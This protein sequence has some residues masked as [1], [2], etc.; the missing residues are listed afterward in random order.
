M[1]KQHSKKIKK[2]VTKKKVGKKIGKKTS[3]RTAKPTTRIR[4]LRNKRGWTLYDVAD[5]LGVSPTLISKIE[6]GDRHMAYDL[7]EKAAKLFQ[8]DSMYELYNDDT[9]VYV[10]A[11]PNRRTRLPEQ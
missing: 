2:K 7:A 6:T 11:R 4:E 5:F 3:K 1:P 10:V 9:P 8:I